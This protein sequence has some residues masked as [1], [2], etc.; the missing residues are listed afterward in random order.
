MPGQ[1]FCVEYEASIVQ[2]VCTFLQRIF[3]SPVST[4]LTHKARFVSFWKTEKLEGASQHNEVSAFCISRVST[5][6][7]LERVSW[8]PGSLCQLTVRRHFWVCMLVTPKT[9][10]YRHSFWDFCFSSMSSVGNVSVP[11]VLSNSVSV[12]TATRTSLALWLYS[13][14][15][16]PFAWKYSAGESLVWWQSAL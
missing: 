6:K 5:E 16:I 9:H 4:N 1:W 13:T 2:C 10:Q 3:V 8:A 7:G 14:P 15:H 12:V 11:S